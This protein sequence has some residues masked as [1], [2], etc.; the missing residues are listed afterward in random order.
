MPSHAITT[1][2]NG[3][4]NP[5]KSNRRRIKS[6]MRRMVSSEFS[7]PTDH[8]ERLRNVNEIPEGRIE[9]ANSINMGVQFHSAS[10]TEC[11]I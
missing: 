11:E 1:T 8:N 4:I 5:Q 7:A 10:G 2:K 6:L 9:G 3:T